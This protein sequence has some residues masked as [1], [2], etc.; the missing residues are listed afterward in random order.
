MLFKNILY[1]IN[2]NR[3]EASEKIYKQRFPNL[4]IAFIPQNALTDL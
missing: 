4:K 2:G 3:N 1:K